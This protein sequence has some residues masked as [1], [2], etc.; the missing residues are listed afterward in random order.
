M[1]QLPSGTL[2]ISASAEHH[3]GAGKEID[4]TSETRFVFE[5]EAFD[6]RDQRVRVV[7][8]RTQK[9]VEDVRVVMTSLGPRGPRK[10][11]RTDAAGEVRFRGFPQGRYRLEVARRPR[12]EYY[13][14]EAMLGVTPEPLTLE[15]EA[16]ARV[17]VVGRVLDLE[18]RPVVNAR[19]RGARNRPRTRTDGDGRFEVRAWATPTAYLVARKE[20]LGNAG[21]ALRSE[22]ALENVIDV[23][24]LVLRDQPWHG[25]TVT[26]TILKRQP[27]SSEKSHD[28]N[29]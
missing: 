6:P 21:V 20:G 4:T 2:R 26:R 5:L 10:E 12:V 24:D 13:V 27:P 15:V 7:D 8:R 19:I 29:P 18:G 3:Y 11:E 25:V 16:N 23:G 9:P 22:H 17:L 28:R 14:E 1:L